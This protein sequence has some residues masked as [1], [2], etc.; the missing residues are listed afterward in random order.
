[1]TAIIEHK[2]AAR[3]RTARSAPHPNPPAA[4]TAPAMPLA[5]PPACAT[6]TVLPA[7]AAG[8]RRA[9]SPRH[10]H[11]RSEPDSNTPRVFQIWYRHDQRSRLDPAFE[12]YDNSAES[13][14]LLE[15]RVFVELSQRADLQQIPLWGALSWKFGQKTGL[16]GQD[17]LGRIAHQPGY[18]AYYCNPHTD[19]EALYH[20]MW[21]QGETA[22]PNFLALCREVFDVAGLPASLLVE[23]QPAEE[24]A[25]CNYIVATPAFW[26]R[27]VG[28][29]S[30]VL[31]AADRKLSPTARDILY[32]P[33]ADPG[34]AH[35]NA[36]YI[37]FLVERL[38]AV[39]LRTEG[40][41]LRA[42]KIAVNGAGVNA[43]VKLLG[44]MK[45]FALSSGSMWMA[46]CWINYRNLYL[47]KLYGNGWSRKFMR[48]LTPAEVVLG[49]SRPARLQAPVPA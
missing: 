7:P 45:S 28:F 38:F 10:T 24:F 36:S 5:A 2:P 11:A 30:R 43:H 48:A 33:N 3:K 41:D 26:K 29:V 23:I 32:S 49:G 39:F 21:L 19:M 35:G 16:S 27:Y 25:S 14:A 40:R 31:L 1:M 12:P 20:N 15:F 18:D 44:E 46:S 17:F 13:S 9:R 34:S 37:P 8:S 4:I 47:D 22:H 42:R 6:A